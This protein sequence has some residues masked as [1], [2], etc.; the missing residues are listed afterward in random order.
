[1]V[2]GQIRQRQLVGVR[3]TLEDRGLKL[4]G[5][6]IGVYYGVVDGGPTCAAVT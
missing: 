2:D 1:M 6:W 4:G 3:D 5:R